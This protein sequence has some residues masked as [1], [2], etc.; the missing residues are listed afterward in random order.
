MKMNLIN[1]THLSFLDVDYRSTIHIRVLG[2][3]YVESKYECKT[4]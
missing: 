1:H 3:S 4:I 2:L